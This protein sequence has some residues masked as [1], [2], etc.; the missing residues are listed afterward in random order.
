M[1]QLNDSA[2]RDESQDHLES[3]RSEHRSLDSLI[4][5][6]A[7]RPYLTAEDQVEM[8]RL[9]KLK[10]RLK[11]EIFAEASRLGVDV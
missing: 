11:D 1:A 7:A 8:A 2:S 3:L 4:G 10:L 9:K 6:L 5:D